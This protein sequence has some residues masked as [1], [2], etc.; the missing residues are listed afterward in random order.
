MTLWL[1]TIHKKLIWRELPGIA[2]RTGAQ[3]R[4]DTTFLNYAIAFVVLAGALA[5]GLA[6]LVW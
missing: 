3:C 1:Y 2:G 6:I 5:F 4:M